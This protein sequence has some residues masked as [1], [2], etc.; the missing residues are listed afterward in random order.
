VGQ[1]TRSY[2]TAE[3]V[4]SNY[5]QYASQIT[6]AARDSFLDGQQW[7]FAAG[8]FAM[9]LGMALVWFAYPKKEEE[10]SLF[11]EYQSAD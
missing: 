10:V 3:N 9:A 7:A 8:A 6:N 4:A 11:A 1:L 5:P 2:N